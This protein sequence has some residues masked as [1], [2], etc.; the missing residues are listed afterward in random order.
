[1]TG[2]P[3]ASDIG[4]LKEAAWERLIDIYNEN[5]DSLDDELRGLVEAYIAET[6]VG[7]GGE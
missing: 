4:E 3:D 2:N 6:D 7:Y 1:M 5:P